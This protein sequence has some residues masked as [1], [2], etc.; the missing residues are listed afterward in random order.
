MN[1]P[2]FASTHAV[3]MCILAKLWAG[4]FWLLREKVAGPISSDP[5]A[6]ECRCAKANG[7]SRRRL[8]NVLSYFSYEYNPSTSHPINIA[9]SRW[10]YACRSAAVMKAWSFESDSSA[11]LVTNDVE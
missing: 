6:C 5:S 9:K 3:F 10:W 7:T 8:Q 11:V 2:L 1:H 4:Q